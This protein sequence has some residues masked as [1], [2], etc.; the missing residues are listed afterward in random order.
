MFMHIIYELSIGI[1]SSSPTQML[2]CNS[3]TFSGPC[4]GGSNY[5]AHHK[6]YLL[7]DWF[8]GGNALD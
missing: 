7:T 3:D 4:S 6:N 2:F 8:T 1:Y 5:S